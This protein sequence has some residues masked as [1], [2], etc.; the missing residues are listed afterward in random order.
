MPL[1]K[2]ALFRIA[3]ATGKPTDHA[4]Y[5]R[6]RNQVV[7]MLRDGKQLF[8]DHNVD[9]KTFWKT[10]QLLNQN[11]SSPTLEDIDL[12]IQVWIRLP[13]HSKQFFLLLFQ[14]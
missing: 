13:H 11:Y 7:S 6:K 10:I 2:D 8:F 4:K 1:R 12:L 3:K 14:P 9:A 5:N